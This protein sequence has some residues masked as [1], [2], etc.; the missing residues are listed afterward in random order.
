MFIEEKGNCF[1]FELDSRFM[2]FVLWNRRE[3][4]GSAV[5]ID[6]KKHY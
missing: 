6:K 1:V 3:K 5:D 4:E 2:V